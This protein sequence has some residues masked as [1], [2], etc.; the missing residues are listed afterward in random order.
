MWILEE[1]LKDEGCELLYTEESLSDLLWVPTEFRLTGN[2][3]VLYLGGAWLE[4]R[5]G[6]RQY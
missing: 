6:H 4:S 2:A 3:S 5:L 1:I